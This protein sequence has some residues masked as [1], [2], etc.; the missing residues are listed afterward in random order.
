MNEQVQTMINQLGGAGR[1]HAMI[2][3]KNFVY[4]NG[5]AS[6]AFQHMRGDKGINKTMVIYDPDSDTYIIT[7]FKVGRT[8]CTCK[9]GAS[10]VYAD[11]LV[12]TIEQDTGLTLR[13]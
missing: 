10:G 7:Y 11:Q 13:M 6:I 8:S 9:A 12:S 2:G 3:A 5:M 1:L 4:D